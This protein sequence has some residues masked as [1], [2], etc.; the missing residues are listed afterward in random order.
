MLAGPLSSN[1]AMVLKG[2]H[3]T[4]GPAGISASP[5]FCLSDLA[6]HWPSQNRAAHREVVM[7]TDGIDDYD[8]HYDPQDSYVLGAI[9]DSAHAG[10]VVYA[11]YWVDQGRPD[12]SGWAQNACQNL[13][14]EVTEA[15]GGDSFWEGFGNPVS[16]KPYF[17]QLHQKLSNQ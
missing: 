11:F 8:P 3:L 15:S 6:K 2:L 17:R 10:L 14:Q 7:V 9:S 13:L 1:P 5:Y 12:R 4:A 16:F